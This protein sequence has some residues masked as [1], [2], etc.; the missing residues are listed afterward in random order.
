MAEPKTTKLRRPDRESGQALVEAVL[1]SLV[2]AMIAC[3]ALEFGTYFYA[4]DAADA[5][6]TEAA[7]ACLV[8][9]SPSEGA[10]R[11]AAEQA[12]KGAGE[13]RFTYSS[14][15]VTAE[16]YTHYLPKE[17][18]SS[19]WD[20]RASTTTSETV[21]VRAEITRKPMTALGRAVGLATGAGGTYTVTSERTFQADETTSS[22][23]W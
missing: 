12:A 8:G 15:G 2:I 20:E 11:A 14:G 7:R 10:A 4:V 5:A 18:G 22:R 21:T 9:E 17:D 3:A 13:L 1:L 6:T 16:S 23:N 19:G